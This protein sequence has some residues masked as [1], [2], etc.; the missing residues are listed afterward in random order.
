MTVKEANNIITEIEYI[1]NELSIYT[2]EHKAE[3][4]KSCDFYTA[5]KESFDYLNDYKKILE[6]KILDATLDI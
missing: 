1:R 6:K 3:L 2:G 5:L 4:E